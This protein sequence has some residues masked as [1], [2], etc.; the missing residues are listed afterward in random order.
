MKKEECVNLFNTK[1]KEFIQD[2]NRVYP[3]D[4][5]LMK[6]KASVNM[7]LVVSDR[8]LIKI[9]KDMVYSRYR[10][11]ILNKEEEFFMN[12]DYVDERGEHSEEFTERLISKIK[13]YWKTMTAEN[14][15]IVWSYF[16]LL[17]KLCE[18]YETL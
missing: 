15:E 13:S 4:D 16:T 12:H 7:L 5:D 11:Q 6:F 17:T 2:L 10:T 14:R 9:Y 8:Q 3:D 18:K 1:I